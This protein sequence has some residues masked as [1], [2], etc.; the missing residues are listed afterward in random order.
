MR[1]CSG[2]AACRRP[3]R[4]GYRLPRPMKELAPDLFMLSGFPPAAFHVYAI[5]SDGGAILVDTAPRFARRRITLQV[6][7]ELEAILITHAHRDHAGSMHAIA[8]A[9]GSPV[10]ASGPDADTLEGKIPEP[11][12]PAAADSRLYGVMSRALKW[13]RHP[14]ARRLDEGDIVGGFEVIAFPGHT[15]GQIG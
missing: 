11:F 4:P 12:P 9:T 14:V 10:W 13:D 3:R 5:R 1:S 15:P 2:R 6:E 8:R 7:G